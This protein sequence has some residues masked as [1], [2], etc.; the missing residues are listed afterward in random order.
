MVEKVR[1]LIVTA[2]AL[3]PTMAAA[4][5]DRDRAKCVLD[6]IE[7]YADLCETADVVARGIAHACS[8]VSAPLN[9]RPMA[10]PS[11]QTLP[12]MPNPDKALYWDQDL[13]V[14]SRFVVCPRPGWP[15]GNTS[16][17]AAPL[18]LILEV[19]SHP[20]FGARK[21]DDGPKHRA[22][23]CAP[24]RDF[25]EAIQILRSNR[26]SSNERTMSGRVRPVHPGGR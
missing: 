9:P 7:R 26:R 15:V 21:I 12:I 19:S 22:L 8:P 10:R 11:D 3:L 24:P 4:Q 6:R 18:P 5:S 14:C 17:A 23:H 2:L 20:P 13:S 16:I 1:A 25:Q